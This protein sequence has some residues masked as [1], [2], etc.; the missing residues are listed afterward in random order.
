MS[1]A[2]LFG[3]ARHDKACLLEFTQ[4]VQPK[5]VPKP[6][7][8]L[9]RR[10][11]ASAL[12][13]TMEDIDIEARNI[14]AGKPTL[15]GFEQY[16]DRALPSKTAAPAVA[17]V[18]LCNAGAAMGTSPGNDGSMTPCSRKRRLSQASARPDQPLHGQ[19]RESLSQAS[20][21]FGLW[22]LA[23]WQPWQQTSMR[24]VV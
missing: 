18:A 1:L 23:A 6:L 13:T 16:A 5:S 19:K 4:Q 12:K 3:S 9:A 15:P 2:G 10:I 14:R 20:H 24:V 8:G 11:A 7:R 22:N 21:V 17:C